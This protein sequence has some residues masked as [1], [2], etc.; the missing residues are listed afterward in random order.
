MCSAAVLP[1]RRSF[2]TTIAQT[3]ARFTKFSDKDSAG[4]IGRE[5]V[6]AYLKARK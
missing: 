3:H 1:L 5:T 4:D 6:E 2:H